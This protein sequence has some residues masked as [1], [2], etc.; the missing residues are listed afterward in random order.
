[1][2]Y[3]VVIPVYNSQNSLEE[4]Y[5]RI[6]DSLQKM[7]NDFEIIFVDD[8]SSDESWK[9]LNQIKSANQ[10]NNLKIVSFA[11]NYGQHNAT[12]CGFRHSKGNIV[13][14]LDDDLQHNPEDLP[15]LI[16][17]LNDKNSDVIFGVPTNYQYKKGYR[18]Y[19]SKMWKYGTHKINN[20]LED[21]SSFR[22]IKKEIIDKLTSHQQQ[23]IFIDEMLGWYTDFISIER[24]SFNKT[25]QKKSGYS[26]VKLFFMMLD[27]GIFYSSIPLKIMTYGGLVMSFISF[28]IGLRFIYKKLFIGVSVSGYTSLMV[29]ILFSTSILLLCLGVIGQYLGR[30][31]TVLNHKPTYSVK[32]QRL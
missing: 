17:A 28:I 10:N 20:A 11:K 21:G 24:V 5:K 6:N 12:M 26:G 1:M 7:S 3:S 2:E 32:E 9:V 13:I 23:F 8:Y 14:T 19:A 29:A 22:V 25:E 27:L 31:Y 18:R 15:Q 30:I 16:A 4:L